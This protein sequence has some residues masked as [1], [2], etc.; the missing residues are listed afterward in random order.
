LQFHLIEHGVVDSTNE[1]ALSALAA[2]TARNGDVHV[3]RGQLQG[4]GRLGRRWESPAGEG[5]YMSAILLPDI[6]LNPSGLTI[7]AGVAV[8]GALVELGVGNVVLKW[9][10]DVLVGSSKIAGILVESRALQ[11]EGSHY[12]VGI[13]INVSQTSFPEELQRERSVTSV[14]MSG[15]QVSVASVLELMLVQL[16]SKLEALAADP[17]SL[18]DE[19]LASLGLEGRAVTAA[20]GAAAHRGTLRSLSLEHGIELEQEDG[21]HRHLLLEHVRSLEEATSG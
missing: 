8:R 7:A 6:A 17:Q 18:C 4:R 3:A 2:G 5:L 11:R 15:I 20:L 10:N 14:A 21:S 1:R 13:G 9:P 16:A 19:F 12:V